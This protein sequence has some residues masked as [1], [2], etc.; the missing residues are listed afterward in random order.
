MKNGKFNV[1]VGGQ[2]GSEGKG[3]A[4][5]ALAEKFRPG[6]ISTTSMANAGHTAVDKDGI[7]K[8][9]GKA[10][11]AAAAVG[12]WGPGDG[13]DYKPMVVVGPGAAFHLERVLE[14]V[15]TLGLV[16]CSTRLMIHERAGVITEEHRRREAG[17]PG[18]EGSTK[19]VASTMQG[20]GTFLADKV[21]R[22][23]DLR[24]AR[25]YEELTSIG[26]V[27][28]GDRILE[29]MRGKTVLHE[30]AQGFS[31]DVN[32]GSHYP[33]CTSRGTSAMQSAADM[34]IGAKRVGE[35]YLVIRPYPIRVGNVV[36]GGVQKGHS[37]GCYEDQQEISWRDVAEMAGMPEDVRK[38]L[39]GRE[40]TTVTKRLRRVFSFSEE[41]LRLSAEVNGATGVFLNFAN[42]VDWA[43]HEVSSW[44]ELRKFDKVMEFVDKCEAAAGVPVVA[45]GTGARWCDVCW[46]EDNKKLASNGL[47]PAELDAGD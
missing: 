11:P 5:S 18:N 30:G 6:V 24:L 9:V 27:A 35:V 15:E 19:H 41:Q 47:Y 44:E 32:W 46:R 20:C 4:A 3:L 31:L 26:V 34:G 42:Y 40:L 36:E 45:A 7:K 12:T 38:G 10:L 23:E 8:F 22:K 33:Q 37:G 1:V 2:W 28:S 17:D 21:L 39:E 14:E 29:M 43:C 13:S 16:G 25:D